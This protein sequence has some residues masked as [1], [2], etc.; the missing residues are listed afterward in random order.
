[1]SE[2][3]SLYKGRIESEYHDETILITSIK[4]TRV[5]KTLVVAS[6]P[7]NV[8]KSPSP[9]LITGS[10]DAVSPSVSGPSE[11][12][13]SNGVKV[14]PLGVLGNKK[15]VNQIQS[16]E[17]S[18][19][20]SSSSSSSIKSSQPLSL[21][22]YYK[23]NTLPKLNQI[24]LYS[25]KPSVI[26]MERLLTGQYS[27]G[28]LR[29]VNLLHSQRLKEILD[30]ITEEI[31]K[32]ESINDKGYVNTT[33]LSDYPVLNNYLDTYVKNKDSD[34]LVGLSNRERL[35]KLDSSLSLREKRVLIV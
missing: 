27:F 1:M 12:K 15:S 32:I 35:E 13:V 28:D 16:R 19:S 33:R 24:C 3:R 7:D 31:S 6:L 21:V 14:A 8:D 29:C 23:I 11:S 5:V 17:F 20:S 2:L 18:S 34:V 10:N 4:Y 25:R 9:P 30:C 22:P 26:T